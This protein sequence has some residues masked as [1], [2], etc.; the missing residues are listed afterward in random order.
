MPGI[1]V[2]KIC[3]PF[4]GGGINW[5]SYWETRK[6]SD[7]IVTGMRD[8]EID[9]SWT[10]NSAGD[11]SFKVYKSTDGVNF[12]AD[13]T[14]VAGDTT[15][16]ATGL[17]A[18]TLYY[19]YVVGVKSSNE[20]DPTDTYDTRFKITVDTTK[21][22]SA[23]DTFILGTSYNGT[24]NYYIDWGDGGTES[25]VTVNT[26]QT[27]VYTVS[28]TYQVKIRG[29]FPW[30]YML[31]G[32]YAKIT[33]ID[34]WG[35]IK[36]GTLSRKA[37]NSCSNMIGTFIDV[38][39]LSAAQ[40]LSNF[41]SGCSSF[42]S[43]INWSIPSATNLS[44]F[45]R[46]DVKLNKPITLTNAG[47]VKTLLRFLS[48]CSLFNSTVTIDDTGSVTDMTYMF[49]EDTAFD[50]SVEF[51]YESLTDATGMFNNVTLSVANYEAIINFMDGQDVRDS[52]TFGGGNSY[53]NYNSDA[54][55]VRSHLIDTHSWTFVDNGTTFDKGKVIFTFDDGYSTL[56]S[57]A[58]SIFETEG[59]KGTFYLT[60][61]WMGTSGK[62]TWA[63]AQTMAA[64][65]HDMQCHTKD[66]ANFS[67]LSDAQILD[68]LTG[69]EDAFVANSLSSPVH[70]AYPQGNCS[71]AQALV[72]ATKRSSGRGISE[73]YF[74][75]GTNKYFIPSYAIDTGSVPGG[76]AVAKAKR[77]I[78]EVALSH[79]AATFYAHQIDV[80]GY[81]TSAQLTEI[82]Q[83]AKSANVDILTISQIYALM[84]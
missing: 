64:A 70:T 30:L 60:S 34:N 15:Y 28:G 22:G 21:A 71:A 3:V 37:F 42:N 83:Y 44:S 74:T 66:H 18:G 8:T 39:N 13:G 55:T 24:F 53:I 67:T 63:N 75:T 19:F 46:D 48:G 76:A 59:I 17:T 57:A 68:E 40:D 73:A 79:R 49:A 11:C 61:D 35:N 26:P 14:T 50:Q 82:V 36:W 65:G 80:A 47:N 38:P 52:V 7:L 29:T 43:E 84:D 20:S 27:H 33:S 23:N 10:D 4:G 12:S 5:S 41:L 1:S 81:L 77:I 2:S 62:M 58:Y 32:D 16:T 78:D 51:S 69:C 56:Y 72:V 9:F 6:P 45:L 31:N 54:A 25:H